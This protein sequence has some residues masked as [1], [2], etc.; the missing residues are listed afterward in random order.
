MLDLV[1]LDGYLPPLPFHRFGCLYKGR[2]MKQQEQKALVFTIASFCCAHEISRPFLYS[3]WQRG[4]GPRTMRIGSRVLISDE[5]A[6]DW[7]KDMEAA[8][9]NSK[10]AA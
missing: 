8:T 1:G 10:V 6:A 3:L 5:A 4:I 9:I 2:T 7:R